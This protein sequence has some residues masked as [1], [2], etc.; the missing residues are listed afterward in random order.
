[1]TPARDLARYEKF[2]W[3]EPMRNPDSGLPVSRRGY[4]RLSKDRRRVSGKFF[5]KTISPD[6]SEKIEETP[7]WSAPVLEQDEYLAL[8]ANVGFSAQVLGD[9]GQVAPSEKTKLLCFVCSLSQE[10]PKRQ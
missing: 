7:S 3:S 9:Y 6:G 1:M 10:G 8:F 4:V 2:G 5:Y